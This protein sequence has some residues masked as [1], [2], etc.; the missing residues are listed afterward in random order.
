MEGAFN[1]RVGERSSVAVSWCLDQYE[2]RIE[3]SHPSPWPYVIC[4]RATV[5][6]DNIY[7]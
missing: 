1:I 6:I 4:R 5:M 3:T 7:C 2:W